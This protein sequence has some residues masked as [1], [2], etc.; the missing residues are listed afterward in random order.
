MR[1]NTNSPDIVIF[2]IIPWGPGWQRPH[3]FARQLIARGHRVVYVTPHVA[4]DGE[5]WR[6]LGRAAA[7]GE[8]HEWAD[9][10]VQAQLAARQKD[11]IHSGAPW[12]EQDLAH[13]HH[14]FRRM[15]HDL[16]LRAP[17]LF[18]QSPCWWPLLAY[19]RERS[20]FPLVYDCLDEHAGWNHEMSEQVRT[21][22]AEL[23]A[24]AG[25]VLA[26]APRLHARLARIAADVRLVPN[27]CDASHFAT[28][29]RPN[30]VLKSL[31]SGPVI[32]Y[33][34][35]MSPGWFDTALVITLAESRPDW[36]F[37]CI[38]PVDESVRGQLEDTPNIVLLGE[39]P[40][41]DLPRY[42]ADFDVAII[43][44]LVNDLTAAVDP[45]KLHEY[46]AAEKPVVITPLP[47]AYELQGLLCVAEDAAAFERAIARFLVDPGDRAARS[48]V[49]RNASWERRVDAFYPALL[50]C[51]PA[52]DVVVA[53]DAWSSE[54]ERSIESIP[55]DGSYPATL[56][57]M[58]RTGGIEVPSYLRT[59]VRDG[60]TRIVRP[61][62]AGGDG[63]RDAQRYDVGHARQDD[64]VLFVEAPVEFPPGTLLG[65][66][67]TLMGAP[68]V[69][70][71][72]AS[73]DCLQVDGTRY[74]PRFACREDMISFFDEHAW[75][76]FE[77]ESADSWSAC[78]VTICRRRELP[79]DG[80]AGEIVGDLSGHE[81]SAGPRRGRSVVAGILVHAATDDGA[82]GMDPLMCRV[83]ADR[84][85]REPAARAEGVRPRA[86]P[87]VDQR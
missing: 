16:R 47:A 84:T 33:Y 9:H 42:A 57:V 29:A 62:R 5:T 64:Y 30:G 14:C 2:G 53:V 13:A 77:K 6:D 82:T 49:A 68:E 35:A 61:G 40:Y 43:P 48:A 7:R 8:G 83:L 21:W 23:T 69:R 4:L 63:M 80:P 52:L 11:S 17:I 31:R 87:S 86:L 22:E 50:G 41:A 19:I 26:S 15:V 58:D 46:F 18:T 25:L 45:V 78:A 54:L 27:G 34:G 59:L 81:P 36:S 56:T 37:V 28:S 85:R 39:V 10:L 74:Q 1:W 75:R 73:S 65:L 12:T 71:A 60:A 67:N 55:R 20:E 51:L 76:H 38:G 72:A 79:A 32:G 70:Q 24:R 3:H 44:F 66:V